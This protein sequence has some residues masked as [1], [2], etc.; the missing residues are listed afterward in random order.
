MEPDNYKFRLFNIE[1]LFSQKSFSLYHAQAT[2]QWK[3]HKEDW[4][5]GLLGIVS[6]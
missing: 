5:L 6:G 4:K 3:E 2:G 1:N